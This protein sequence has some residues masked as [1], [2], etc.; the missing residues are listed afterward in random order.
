MSKNHLDLDRSPQLTLKW[1][2]NDYVKSFY[3]Y[4]DR[5]RRYLFIELVFKQLVSA[6]VGCTARFTTV[7]STRIMLR[8]PPCIPL[9]ET[10]F[11][12]YKLF[13]VL[14]EASVRITRKPVISFLI[15][16]GPHSEGLTITG[17]SKS[18]PEICFEIGLFVIIHG[19]SSLTVLLLD[20]M[21]SKPTLKAQLFVWHWL[22]GSV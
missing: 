21:T 17:S 20:K 5:Y 1:P 16:S 9:N 8:W 12:L 2:W 15:C 10:E 18:R 7:E 19:L 14:S 13:Q 4:S 11:F 3:G 6:V 22:F